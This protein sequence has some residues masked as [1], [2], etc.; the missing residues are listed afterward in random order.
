MKIY[1]AGSI[2]NNPNYEKQFAEAEKY[3]TE[4]GCEVFNP[5]KN[6]EDCYKDYIDTG[7]KQ[8]MR[9]DAICMLSG[10]KK[11]KGA[12]LEIK[13]AKAVG[14]PIIY[15]MPEAERKYDK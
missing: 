9:C 12:S 13:Y 1:I 14:I 7:L 2:T 10:Y 5:A 8:L 15:K 6:K 4:K 11:S 3:F